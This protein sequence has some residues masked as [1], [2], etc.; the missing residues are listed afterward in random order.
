MDWPICK[1][2]NMYA[3][4]NLGIQYQCMRMNSNSCFIML[5]VAVSRETA[6]YTTWYVRPAKT[7]ISLHIQQSDQIFARRNMGNQSPNYS[8]YRQRRR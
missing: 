4:F 8:S 7:Q 6:K 2:D 1:S 3:C 5:I